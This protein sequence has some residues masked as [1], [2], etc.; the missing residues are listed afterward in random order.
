MKFVGITT[1][2]LLSATER[3]VQNS[4]TELPNDL[5]QLLEVVHNRLN[6]SI[7]AYFSPT[8]HIS[9]LVPIMSLTCS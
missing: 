7:I 1:Y 3:D 6:V 4:L 5:K 8:F 2:L 9:S